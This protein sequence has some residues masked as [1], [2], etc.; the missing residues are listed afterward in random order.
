MSSFRFTVLGSNSAIPSSHRHPSS[1]LLTIHERVYLIDAGE[2]VQS[3]IKRA[4]SNIHKIDHIFISHLHGDHFYGI[5]GLISTLSLLGREK[6]LHIYAPSPIEDVILNHIKFFE[7]GLS[8][9]IICHTTDHKHSEL[10]YENSVM[11]VFTIPLKHRIGCCGY[12]FKE[13]P[14]KLNVHKHKISEHG[15]GIAQIAA[16]KR[17]EDITLSSG[18]LLENSELSYLPYVPRSF[19]YC[20]DTAYSQKVIDLVKGV[21]LL[22]H[23]ATFLETDKK[24]AKKTGHSTALDAA[25]VANEAEVKMLLLGHFS[26]R[27]DSNNA[28]FEDEARQLFTNSYAVEELKSYTLTLKK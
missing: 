13:K 10:I 25:R 20:S 8:Y 5:Y 2:G 6:E 18:E 24:M 26:H 16:V 7:A 27:Y 15:L 9:K 23:E 14:P 12:L 19:A 21:D 11:Q 4:G 3:Q 22:Y 1:H 28:L 17:G